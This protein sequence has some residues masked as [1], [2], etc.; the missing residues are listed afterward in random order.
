MSMD[1]KRLVVVTGGTAVTF[2]RS[3]R[4]ATAAAPTARFFD[5]LWHMR[6]VVV[7][8]VKLVGHTTRHMLMSSACLASQ[9]VD[10]RDDGFLH[11]G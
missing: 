5:S 11:Y 9:I 8:Q 6:T 10:Q 7:R 2:H 1:Y 3:V 4:E